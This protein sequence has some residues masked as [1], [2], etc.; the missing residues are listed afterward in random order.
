MGRNQ[1]G[2][3]RSFFI[4][5]EGNLTP[6]VLQLPIWPNRWKITIPIYDNRVLILRMKIE[7]T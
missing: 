3:D 6:Y 5:T 7:T 2:L 4:I 1:S